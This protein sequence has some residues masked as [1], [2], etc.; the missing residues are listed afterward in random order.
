MSIFLNPGFQIPEEYKGREQTYLKHRV[1]K[2]Y[3]ESWAL[4]LASMASRSGTIRI[5]FVDCFSGPWQSASQALEDTS[6]HI[7]L[8]AIQEAAQFWEGRGLKIELGAIFVEKDKTAYALLKKY[9]STRKDRFP[10]DIHALEGEFGNQVAEIEKL[11]GDDP[12][13]LF[14]DPTGWKGVAMSFI[15]P[16][17]KKRCRDVMI[18]MMYE[19]VNRFKEAPLDYVRQQMIDFFDAQAP[20]D[21]GEEELI[22]FYR[23]QLKKSCELNFSA[24]LIV[25]APCKDRTKFRLVLGANHEA[26]LVLFRDVEKKVLGGEAPAIRTAAKEANRL[27]RT[28]QYALLAPEIPAL[29]MYTEIQ[30]AGCERIEILLSKTLEEDG[31]QT[32]KTLRPLFLQECHLTDSDLKKLLW[33]WKSEGR[34]VVE[35]LGRD[36]TMKD[37]HVLQRLGPPLATAPVTIQ[38]SLFDLGLH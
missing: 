15:A 7:G 5:W 27:D 21:L 34:L 37:G 36:R 26:A 24:D 6:I 18:N 25:Q 10:V 8:E 11:L 29:D 28:G 33:T 3:I 17:A 23:E 31:P 35:G 2:L 19:H 1:L 32:Y 4:K 13:F 30:K 22:S 9:L 12:A 16:L 14:V 20:A 38:T